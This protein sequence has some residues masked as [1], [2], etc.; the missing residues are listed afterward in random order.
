MLFDR[1]AEQRNF[2]GLRAGRVNL[3]ERVREMG[4]LH[5]RSF[6]CVCVS[7]GRRSSVGIRCRGDESKSWCGGMDGR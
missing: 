3:S 7:L 1:L 2:V 4:W 5:V 6:V